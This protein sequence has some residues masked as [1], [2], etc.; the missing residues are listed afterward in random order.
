MALVT[1]LCI[2]VAPLQSPGRAANE[3]LATGSFAQR[4][5]RALNSGSDQD[6]G[7]AVAPEL[8]PSLGRRYQ[9]FRA[10]FPGLIWAV[11]PSE[12]LA[13]GRSTLLVTV[14]G[15]TTLQGVSY[16][17]QSKE[18]LAIRTD[19]GRLVA[20]DVIEQESLLRSGERPLQVTMGIP[21]VVLTGS[22]YDIDLIVDEP[23]GQAI[24]AGGL[25]ELSDQQ[26]A[27]LSRPNLQL[28]PLVSGG[29][30]KS[31]RASQRP[32]SQTWALML[33]HPDGVVTATKRVQIVSSLSDEAHG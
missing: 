23:L 30:F 1:A 19:A 4:L 31:V 7:A 24:L 13:D 32:G 3:P 27:T 8:L 6:L 28:A 21:D 18:R 22:R 2:G 16:Q 20:Q 29:L 10:D 5:Q 25:I 12:P 11:Q 15:A 33:V 26:L 17:L 14:N 9:S